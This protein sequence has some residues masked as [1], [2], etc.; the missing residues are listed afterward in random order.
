MF[1]GYTRVSTP[2]QAST[3]K[4]SIEQQEQVIRGVAMTRGITQFDFAM[5]SDP[6]VSGSIPL[7][8]RPAGGKLMAEVQKGDV[9]CAAKLDRMFRS[10][11]DALKIAEDLKSRGV[12]LILFDMGADPVT[13]NGMAK[14]FFTMAAAFAELERG[15]INERTLDGRRGKR[16]RGGYIG[17]DPPFGYRSVGTGQTARLEEHPEES[18]V[19]HKIVKLAQEFGSYGPV[20]SYLHKHGY[21]N[22]QGKPFQHIQVRRIVEYARSQ[23]ELDG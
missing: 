2:E 19:R 22:R 10:A 1:L 11:L 18:R 21:L 4:V 12:D 20:V 16:Q 6:G 5:Y 3:D 7:W 23:G 17:G 14:C 13:H 8:E 9:V 15:R